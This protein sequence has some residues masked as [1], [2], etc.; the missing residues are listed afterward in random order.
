M[1]PPGQRAEAAYDGELK[2]DHFKVTNQPFLARLL[3]AGSFAGLGDLL[4]GEGVSFSHLEQHFQGR[5]DM[6]TL[7]DGTASGP[8]IGLTLQGQVNRDA[9]A[10]DLN[11]TVVPLYGLNGMLSD[12]PVLGELLT[13]RK[14][15]GI[16]GMTY[17]ISG[18]VDEL[19]VAV[20]PIS[21]LAPGIL[22]RIFEMGPAPQVAAPLPQRKPAATNAFQPQPQSGGT[23]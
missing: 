22:R 15:E 4:Q 11:G 3:A 12:F 17:G 21:T 2:I 7:T 10:V 20:N 6:L 23:N 19:K 8:S 9:D 5:G 16:F 1:P 14:G 18:H 13:S